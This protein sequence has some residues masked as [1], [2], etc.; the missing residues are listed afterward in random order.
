MTVSMDETR[1]LLSRLS[2]ESDA[3]PPYL[4]TSTQVTPAHGGPAPA[5][6][7]YH[8]ST[9]S[10]QDAADLDF[11]LNGDLDNPQEWPTPYKWTLVALLAMMAFTVYV[12]I[13]FSISSF[14]LTIPKSLGISSQPPPPLTR[15]QDH[16]KC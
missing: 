3:P 10:D 12:F 6:R 9:D 11:D 14:F 7:D 1:P 5:V 15:H 16:Q 4:A 2:S 13:F 8:N